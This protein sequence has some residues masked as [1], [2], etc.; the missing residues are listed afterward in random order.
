[1]TAVGRRFPPTRALLGFPL[2]KADAQ[3]Q[4]FGGRKPIT[5]TDVIG[6][7]NEHEAVIDL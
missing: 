3:K 5:V 4:I 7:Y 6:F 1:M 2:E